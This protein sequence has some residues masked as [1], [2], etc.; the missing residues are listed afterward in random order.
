MKSI[1]PLHQIDYS[2]TTPLGTKAIMICKR[3]AQK[4]EKKEKE[5][6]ENRS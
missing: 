6:N 1:C 3:C 4:L 2:K 5:K